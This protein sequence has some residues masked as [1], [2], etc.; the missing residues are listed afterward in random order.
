MRANLISRLVLAL[1]FCFTGTM[2][3]VDPAT[4]IAVMPPY[5]PWHRELVL[6]SGF[7]EIA[8]GL[9]L[10]VPWVPLRRAAAIGLVLLLL[11]VFPANIEM[12]AR[13]EHFASLLH[14]PAWLFF[15][16]LPLQILLIYWVIAATGCFT[17]R[18]RATPT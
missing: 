8:G 13:S 17:R 1:L 10:L 12:A 15:V 14:V 3:F 9:G 2:H 4:F 11:A 7:F 18:A 16:R 5:L 6:V